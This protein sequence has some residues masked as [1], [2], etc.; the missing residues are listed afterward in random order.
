MWH[1]D[2]RLQVNDWSAEVVRREDAAVRAR[3]WAWEEWVRKA[4]D[5][6]GASRVYRF[7]EGPAP[8]APLLH[9]GVGEDLPAATPQEL[10]ELKAKPWKELWLPDG[11]EFFPF[12][13]LPVEERALPGPLPDPEEFRG[14]IRSYRWSTAIGADHWAPRSLGMLTDHLVQVLMDF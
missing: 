12:A 2:I 7:I 13:Q 10:V 6:N 4:F 14:L 5:D 1:S 3:K 9:F 8:A 11:A